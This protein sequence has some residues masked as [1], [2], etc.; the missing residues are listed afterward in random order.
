MKHVTIFLVV[1]RNLFHKDYFPTGTKEE[2]KGTTK[3]G[4][5]GYRFRLYDVFHTKFMEKS[6]SRQNF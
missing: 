3:E 1:L 5:Y 6:H 4:C 2:G